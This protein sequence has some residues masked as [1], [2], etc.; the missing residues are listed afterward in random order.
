MK[1]PEHTRKA[2]NNTRPTEGDDNSES[3]PKAYEM[4]DAVLRTFIMN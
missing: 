4:S 2:R 3:A 1:K